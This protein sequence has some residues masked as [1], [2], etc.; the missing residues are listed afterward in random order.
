MSEAL[1][2]GIMGTGALGTSLAQTLSMH[3]YSI[4]CV[5]SQDQIRADHLSKKTGATYTVLL[6]KPLPEGIDILFLCIPD[7]AI[8]PVSSRLA[9]ATAT[10]D[11]AWQ[12]VLVAHTSGALAAHVLDPLATSGAL[13]LSFHPMQTFKREALTSFKGIYI[14]LEGGDTAIAKASPIVHALDATPLVLTAREKVRYHTAAVV[15][16]NFAVAITSTAYEVLES[17]GIPHQDARNILAPLIQQTY[18]NLDA[19]SPEQAIT[20]PAIRGDLET[21]TGHL[22]ELEIHLPK[23]IPLYTSLTLE[24]FRL[25]ERTHRLT[26]TQ[27]DTLTKRIKA[28]IP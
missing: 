3:G 14:S 20:G 4:H 23:L 12:R 1:R 27:L 2:I 28:F 8:A 24:I 22:E 11:Y 21:L 19:H 26:P 18:A 13:T 7:D 16:S 6:G 17:I 5:I 15:A 9:K 25:A 10:R